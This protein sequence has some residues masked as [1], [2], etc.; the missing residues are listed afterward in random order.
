MHSLGVTATPIPFDCAGDLCT[1]Y[2]ADVTAKFKELQDAVNKFHLVTSSPLIGVGSNYGVIGVGTQVAA[3]KALD[4]IAA[5]TAVS[6]AWRGYASLA[7]AF[8]TSPAALANAVTGAAA[9]VSP[10]AVLAH[11]VATGVSLAPPPSS[12][13]GGKTPKPQVDDGFDRDP[14]SHWYDGSTPYWIAG[15]LAALAT[16]WFA[17]EEISGWKDSPKT[18]MAGAR[19]RRRR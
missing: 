16:L 6:A 4:W 8:A 11:V 9:T 19:R 14:N 7:A 5:N 12:G 2:D 1:P 18:A 17:K 15:G 10:T 3:K 13:G